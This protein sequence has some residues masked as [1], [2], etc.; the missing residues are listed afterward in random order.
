MNGIWYKYQIIKIDLLYLSKK[1]FCFTRLS[2]N[3]SKNIFTFTQLQN[4][5]LSTSYI[6]LITIHCCTVNLKYIIYQGINT[7]DKHTLTI[8]I[9]KFQI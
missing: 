6:N 3:C 5:I 8:R 7:I 2:V 9:K 4:L 1:L